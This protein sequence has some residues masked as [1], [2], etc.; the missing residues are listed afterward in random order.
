MSETAICSRCKKD[1]G[2]QLPGEGM[3]AGYYQ[4]TGWPQFANPGEI[5]IC[6]DC[7]WSDARYIAVYGIQP[8]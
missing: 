7:M 6:D 5:F 8:K 4:A 2:M 1:T 3:T